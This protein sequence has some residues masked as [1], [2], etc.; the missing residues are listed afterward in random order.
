MVMKKAKVGDQTFSMWVRSLLLH[1]PTLNLEQLQAAYD[2]SG[3]PKSERPKDMTTIYG[4]R[5]EL[6]KRWGIAN[7]KDIPLLQNGRPNVAQL[8]MLYFAK[9]P[10]STES[11]MRKFF[12]DHGLDIQGRFY[13][14]R[15]RFQK[16]RGSPD[17]NQAS[18]R[19]AGNPGIQRRQTGRKAMPQMINVDS[20]KTAI[21]L[22]NET[23]SLDSARAIL[24]LIDQMKVPLDMPAE[25][26]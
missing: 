26:T 4:Q 16:E 1:N 11:E 23:G 6:C 10:Q 15:N 18:G 17:A 8:A 24:N 12:A 9:Y 7:V 14:L 21:K 13:N 2:K 3:R 5:S 19:R 22:I 25:T 20:I